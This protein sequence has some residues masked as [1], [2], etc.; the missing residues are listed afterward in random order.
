[1]Q[2]R[3]LTTAEAAEALGV[4]DSFVRRLCRDGKLGQRIG[5]NWAVTKDDV[6]R[7]QREIV[8]QKQK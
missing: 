1:M 2:I 5:R 7:Y 6:E 3:Y 8:K 4:S